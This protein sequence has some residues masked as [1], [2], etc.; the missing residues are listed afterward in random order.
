M[1]LVVFCV[2]FDHGFRCAPPAAIDIES[3]HG[4]FLSK[5][6]VLI[7]VAPAAAKT[8]V[9][10]GMPDLNPSTIVVNLLS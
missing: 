1:G 10:Q 6:A 3:P 8:M 9:C 5:D 7:S 4:L 2:S